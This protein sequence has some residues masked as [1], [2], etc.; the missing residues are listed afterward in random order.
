MLNIIYLI[1]FVGICVIAAL[2]TELVRRYSLQNEIIDVPNERSSHNIPTPRGGG[3]SIVVM[4]LLSL[5]A[6]Y[7]LDLIN[8]RTFLAIGVGGMI[9]AIMGWLDDHKNLKPLLRGIIYS[10]AVII[11]LSIIGGLQ[12]IRIGN[13]IISIPLLNDILAF[14]GMF[15]LINLYNFMDGTD[16]LAGMQTI[17]AALAGAVFF[18][19]SGQYGLGLF[20]VSIVASTAGF[21][22]WN[23]PPAKIFMG[24]VGSCYLGF[25]FGI[26]AIIGEKTETLNISIFVILLGLF[27][28]DATF[29]LLMRVCRK[30]KWYSPHKSHAY[31]RLVQMGLSHKQL[32]V[33]MTLTNVVLLLPFSIIVFIRQEYSLFILIFMTII[34]FV[35]WA[36]VQRKFLVYIK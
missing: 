14:L 17:F 36:M 4:S 15:W 18:I 1:S 32:A 26:M 35:F 10:L 30:E 8:T 24:D 22:Y 7:S 20:C 33:G 29:T 6:I 16:A 31:Q 34:L 21:L 11:S 2:I 12:S 3:I 9:V 23:W 27:I 13:H 19:L 25:C 5:V 28:C